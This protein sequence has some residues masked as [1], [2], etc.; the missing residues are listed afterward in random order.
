MDNAREENVIVTVPTLVGVSQSG[1]ISSR[2][3][4]L[5]SVHQTKPTVPVA[6]HSLPPQPESTP[7]S[8]GL[9]SSIPLPSLTQ[10]EPRPFDNLEWASHNDDEFDAPTGDENSAEALGLE[11]ESHAV[12]TH[13]LIL[14]S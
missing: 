8:S 14:I 2:K 1:E 7:A 12:R 10:Y 9:K 11:T 5:S 3:A 6:P 13:L 4:A